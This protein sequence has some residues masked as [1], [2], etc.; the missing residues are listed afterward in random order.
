MHDTPLH[1]MDSVGPAIGAVIFVLLMSLVREPARQRINAF[2]AA[3]A[4]GVY[5]SGG[6]GPWEL[7]FPVL[8]L[9]VAYLG[10]RS[11]RFIGIAWLLHSC[12]DVAHHL[13]GNPIWPFM[14]T[15]SYGCLIFD[16]L[17]ASW[18]LAG[19]PSLLALTRGVPDPAR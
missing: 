5:L 11:Y 3:G 12:W 14:P 2:L 7:L 8:A 15:S 16:A 4:T 6:F 19:A 17:I 18:F 9:P 10:L 1:V 13:W